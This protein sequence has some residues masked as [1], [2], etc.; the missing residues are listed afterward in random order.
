MIDRL[1]FAGRVM[2]YTVCAL[3]VIV[4]INN[5]FEGWLK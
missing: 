3:M 4:A 5:F 1:L 2:I